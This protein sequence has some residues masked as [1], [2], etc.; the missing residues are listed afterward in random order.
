MRDMQSMAIGERAALAEPADMTAAENA[1]GLGI[2]RFRLLK[3]WSLKDLAAKSGIPIS[4]LSKV[5]NGQMS[6][7]LERLLR[8]TAALGIDVMQLVQPAEPET[9][10]RLIT[11]RRSIT[12]HGEAKVVQTEN[13]RYAHHAADFSHRLLS[14]TVIEV[15]PGRNPEP[16]RHQGEEFIFVL[17]GRVEVMTEFYEPMVLEVGES[18]Y[19]DSTMA[20]NVRALDGKTA[21]LLNIS[22]TPR[23]FATDGRL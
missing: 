7:K 10:V 5:E 17:E 2:K 3:K 19:I 6:L 1:L 11:G 8:V 12:R 18:L 16:V 9:A 14:P 21:R 22:S 15:F 4:T 20:H 13:G 23:N